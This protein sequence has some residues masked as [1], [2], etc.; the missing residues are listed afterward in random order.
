M[1]FSMWMDQ[2]DQKPKQILGDEHPFVF[3]AGQGFDLAIWSGGYLCLRAD[4]AAG[5][6]DPLFA[7]VKIT[8]GAP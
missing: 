3:L 4:H 7:P 8:A 2:N 1:Y 5:L 6:V